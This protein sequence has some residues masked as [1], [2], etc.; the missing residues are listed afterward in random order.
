VRQ[1]ASQLRVDNDL[2][3]KIVVSFTIANDIPAHRR[4]PRDADADDK[5]S[6]PHLQPAAL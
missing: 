6:N 3:R 2:L 1:I 4:R 5:R